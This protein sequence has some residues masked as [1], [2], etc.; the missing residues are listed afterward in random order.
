MIAVWR[1]VLQKL[2]F[3]LRPQQCQRSFHRRD[4]VG[5]VVHHWLTIRA[6]EDHIYNSH[7]VSVEHRVLIRDEKSTSNL[8]TCA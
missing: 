6:K 4:A 7:V 1:S 2:N 5:E 8:L 3:F